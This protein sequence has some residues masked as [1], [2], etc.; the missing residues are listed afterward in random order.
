MF[1]N[2]CRTELGLKCRCSQ[3]V[4]HANM[5]FAPEY[6]KARRIPHEVVVQMPGD[7]V[8]TTPGAYHQVLNQ[9]PNVAVAVNMTLDLPELGADSPASKK[10][11]KYIYCFNGCGHTEKDKH[12][13]LTED[14][15][16]TQEVWEMLMACRSRADLALE[17]AWEVEGRDEPADM[18]QRSSD[19][20]GKTPSR[21]NGGRDNP[22]TEEQM[23]DFKLMGG[24]AR[25]LQLAHDRLRAEETAVPYSPPATPPSSSSATPRPADSPQDRDAVA[26]DTDRSVAVPEQ[27][28]SITPRA[29]NKRPAPADG[30]SGRGNKK[31]KTTNTTNRP[32]KTLPPPLDFKTALRSLSCL[33]EAYTEHQQKKSAAVDPSSLGSSATVSRAALLVRGQATAEDVTTALAED[34]R[35][36]VLSQFARRVLKMHFAML[37]EE[38]VKRAKADRGNNSTRAVKGEQAPKG[39]MPKFIASLAV[40]EGMRGKLDKTTMG[41]WLKVGKKLLSL[42]GQRWEGR[43]MLALRNADGW[44]KGF[45]VGEWTGGWEDSARMRLL[46]EVAVEFVGVFERQG[47]VGAEALA[48]M[49]EL[50]GGS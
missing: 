20:P 21:S 14:N 45:C 50:L 19:N 12:D 4:R 46:R 41:Q 48:K 36:T 28:S 25:V 32:P 42:A 8:V 24:V 15:L 30:D 29:S 22:L 11:H 43:W 6:L 13:K 40:G 38:R 27:S 23:Q 3:F 16:F 26:A 47:A 9:G 35:E 5:F 33:V 18:S 2:L 49:E 31:T 1:E 7:I 44:D 39:T 37:Y 10:P 34:E 17:V